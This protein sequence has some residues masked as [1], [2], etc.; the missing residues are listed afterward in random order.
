MYLEEIA[1]LLENRLSPRIFTLKNDFYGIQYGDMQNRVIRKI[2]I[3]IDLTLNSIHYAVRNKINLIITLHG[4]LNKPIS[5]FNR[6]QINKLTLLTKQPIIVFVLE[7]SFIAAEGGV[8]DT[9]V[10]ALYLKS[11]KPL[12]VIKKDGERIPIGRICQPKLYPHDAQKLRLENLIQRIKTNF[13]LS[14]IPYVGNLKK[15]I[16]NICIIGG[17][18]NNLTYLEEILQNNCECLI[19]GKISHIEA[20]F[21]KEN[22][23]SLVEVSHYRSAN[24]ALR[25]LCNT[26][27]LEFPRDEFY[28]FSSET[29][30]KIFT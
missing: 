18:I 20:I 14:R 17:E 10:E 16:D 12:D 6:Q 19:S 29:P 15:E 11:L 27:S 9:I 4:F 22:G 8:S 30:I 25:R 13:E 24:V 5:S 3:T 23:I 28:Y 7:S 26:L 21:S 2:M 1:L